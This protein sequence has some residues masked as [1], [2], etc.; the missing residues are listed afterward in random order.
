MTG[1]QTC[2][3]PILRCGRAS[4]GRVLII[5]TWNYPIGLLGVQLVQAIAAGNHVTVKPSER[6]P[7]SQRRLAGLAAACA[8]RG[9][10]E[11]LDASRCEG[12]RAVQNGAFDHVVFTGGTA[13]GRQ[14]AASAAQTLT[15][16]SLELSGSDS[17]LVLADADVR[18]A[19]RRI[20]QAVTLNAGQTCMAPRRA[21]VDRAIYGAFVAEL[22]PLA[23][24]ARSVRLVDADQAVIAGLVAAASSLWPEL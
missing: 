19:A 12:E 16:T 18:Q 8:P 17:A 22:A 11:V 24:A 21:L 14:V 2:A 5:A 10:I 13:T 4:L 3:L 20:W 6:S 9:W 15:P 1:V 7:E 23:A